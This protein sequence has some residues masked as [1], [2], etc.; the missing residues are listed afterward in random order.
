YQS[1][2][3]IRGMRSRDAVSI[4]LSFRGAKATRNL[5]F[6]WRRQEPGSLASLGMTTGALSGIRGTGEGVSSSEC[7]SSP[8]ASSLNR[9]LSASQENKA[10]GARIA[11]SF[12]STA[13]ENHSPTPHRRFSTYASS[14][15]KVNPAAAKS[16]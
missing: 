8:D 1:A 16:K 5:G 7:A 12:A 2:S 15:Q 3:G 6:R 11:V 4:P 10:N 9:A 13:R 14:P